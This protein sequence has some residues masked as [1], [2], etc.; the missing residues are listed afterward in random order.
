MPRNECILR[1]T[2]YIYVC[3]IFL[4]V[5]LFFFGNNRSFSYCARQ[6]KY[7]HVYIYVWDFCLDKYVLF[8]SGKQDLI[9][10]SEMKVTPCILEYINLNLNLNVNI[11]LNTSRWPWHCYI[12]L[13]AN[14]RNL[15]VNSN[16]NLNL[17]L[18]LT[19]SS[20]R[21][22]CIYYLPLHSVFLLFF[23]SIVSR[24]I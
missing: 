18:Y 17:D 1:D 9:R 8:R 13:Y 21:Y 12:L 15:V 24:N 10:G 16:S 11:K 6:H 20:F 3:R 2:P 4:F 19:F 14:L 7:M 5:F 23:K 22:I